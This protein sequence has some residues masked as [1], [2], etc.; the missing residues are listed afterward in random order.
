MENKENIGR[1]L[2][3]IPSGVGV[4]TAQSNGSESA[5][6]ASWF[7][8]AAFDPPMI[9]VAVNNSR[10]IASLIKDSKSFCLSVF[11]TNQKELFAHFAKGF[12][13]GANPFDG[14][15]VARKTTQ[16][17]IL[18]DAMV[19]L[20]CELV[21]V[22]EA[23]DHSLYLGRVVDAGILDDGNSMVHMRKDGFRY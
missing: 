23:G 15:N 5:M 22:T 2:G 8:Q 10:P 21:S 20:D 1:A 7:Q 3:K 19:Y 18:Q 9:S 16:C 14:I 12:E 13:P 17:A 6:L 11:H 4:L